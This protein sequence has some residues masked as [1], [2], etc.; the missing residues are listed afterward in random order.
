[1][2][3]TNH[4]SGGE[5][6]HEPSD[7]SSTSVDLKYRDD[8][9]DLALVAEEEETIRLWEQEVDRIITLL[10]G[11]NLIKDRYKRFRRYKMSF[12]GSEFIDWLVDNNI[13]S[14][15]LEAIDYGQS[16]MDKHVIHHVTNSE[17]FKDG[18]AYYRLQE[19]EEMD[20]CLNLYKIS[21]GTKNKPA[22]VAT[23]IVQ[24]L[25]E[26]LAQLY[27]KCL[28][29]SGSRVDY[30]LLKQTNE[31]TKDYMNAVY[32]LQRVDLTPLNHNEKLAFWINIYNALC[33]HGLVVKGTPT[34]ASSRTSFFYN[35]K[36]CISGHL[37]SLNDIEHGV[38]RGNSVPPGAFI[39]LIRGSDPRRISVLSRKDP[40]IHFALNCGAQSCPPIK[41][42]YS[43]NVDEQLNIASTCF[44]DQETVVNESACTVT[45]SKILYWYYYDF[46]T[47][48]TEVLEFVCRFLTDQKEALSRLLESRN[49][50]KIKYASYNWASN[51]S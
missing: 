14:E 21:M 12:I 16:L 46:G 51:N 41:L 9:D 10:K 1:M 11:S 32:T 27:S 42:Y 38:L 20:G 3:E 26:I 5:Q 22:P 45:L 18:E 43:E 23:S 33:V 49:T 25:R 19:D 35:V 36:Y 24:L 7:L 47:N 6:I 8:M 37:Y 30:S 40:R 13:R 44:L 50:I 29:N 2:I 28:I 31:F 15:R 17:P 39:R 34:S 4:D 48:D